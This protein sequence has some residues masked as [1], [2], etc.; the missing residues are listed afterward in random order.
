VPAGRVLALAMPVPPLARVLAVVALVAAVSGVVV[1][2]PVVPAP[3]AHASVTA[4]SVLVPVPVCL[5]RSPRRAGQAP[6]QS[7]PT[8][9]LAELRS[10]HT[11]D[12]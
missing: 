4:V 12:P 2:G 11:G 7:D 9:E 6:C 8:R 1:L 3:M 10:H 5:A